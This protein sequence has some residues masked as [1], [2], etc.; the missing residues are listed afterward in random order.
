M[1]IIEDNPEQ[2]NCYRYCILQVKPEYRRF[3]ADHSAFILL[4]CYINVVGADI[5][6][7]DLLIARSNCMEELAIYA[8]MRNWNLG[9]YWKHMPTYYYEIPKNKIHS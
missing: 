1:T 4:G 5:Y 7:E 9:K 6:D 8:N 2:Y 3:I